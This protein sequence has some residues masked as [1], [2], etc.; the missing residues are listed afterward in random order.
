MNLLYSLWLRMLNSNKLLSFLEWYFL[1]WILL[2]VILIIYFKVDELTWFFHD[3]VVLIKLICII[4]VTI[5]KLLLNFFV[6]LVFCQLR[7]TV[8]IMVILLYFVIIDCKNI[9]YFCFC[10]LVYSLLYSL[11]LILQKFARLIRRLHMIIIDNRKLRCLIEVL[12]RNNI[13]ILKIIVF[14]LLLFGLNT[15]LLR[16]IFSI[17]LL[18]IEDIVNIFRL[19]LILCLL[20]LLFFIKFLSCSLVHVLLLSLLSFRFFLNS[21]IHFL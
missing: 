11:N 15:L 3:L 12:M 21:I 10:L 16:W 18:K 7:R 4:E 19:K 8:F 1:K 20:F 6:R 9:N 13:R 2:V 14:Y 17:L 5:C